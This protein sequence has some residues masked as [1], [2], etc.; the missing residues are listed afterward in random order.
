LVLSIIKHVTLQK[1]VAHG[2]Q[3]T[4]RIID[5]VAIK[6]RFVCKHNVTMQMATAIEPLAKV[7]TRACTGIK[8]RS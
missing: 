2:F 7:H 4:P 1:I 5:K 3:Y 6:L 8:K